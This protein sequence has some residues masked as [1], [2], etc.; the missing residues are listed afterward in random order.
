MRRIIAGG[1]TGS[2][3]RVTGD[4]IDDWGEPGVEGRVEVG[5]LESIEVDLTQAVD[6]TVAASRA[7]H[8]GGDG[9]KSFVD[10][11]ISRT[12]DSIGTHLHRTL[13]PRIGMI[14]KV[15]IDLDGTRRMATEHNVVRI[16]SKGYADVSFASLW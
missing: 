16:S 13:E 12:R 1:E 6:L 2:V 3:V 11:G 4:V 8:F 5:S 14:P 7:S 10:W 15:V 9:I